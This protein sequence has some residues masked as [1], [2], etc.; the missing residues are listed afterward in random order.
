MS[1]TMSQAQSGG[2]VDGET[3]RA[4]L[5]LHS[6]ASDGTAEVRLAWS[7][8]SADGG[9]VAGGGAIE[10]TAGTLT[11]PPGGAAVVRG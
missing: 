7:G 9:A 6:L 4:D 3:G 10:L 5:H 8:T 1:Q 2:P 11:L